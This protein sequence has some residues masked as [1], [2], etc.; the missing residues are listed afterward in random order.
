MKR[1]MSSV[2]LALLAAG[3]AYAQLKATIENVR[4]IPYSSVPT[5]LKLPPR[6][7][8]NVRSIAIDAQGDVYAA[9]GGNRRIQ[10]F[11]NDGNLKTA[12][13]DVGTAQVLCMTKR[14]NVGEIGNLR[15]QKLVLH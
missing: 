14:P 10:V 15:V 7:F 3:A 1:M 6:E 11:D 4:D 5:L 2:V 8:A 13:T 12:F 9:D